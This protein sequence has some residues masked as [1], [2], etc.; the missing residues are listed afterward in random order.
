M[1]DDTQKLA[2]KLMEGHTAGGD[3]VSLSVPCT[4]IENMVVKT[5]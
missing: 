2:K 1:A 5:G 4:A 3:L